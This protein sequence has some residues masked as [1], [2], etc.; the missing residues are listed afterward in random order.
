RILAVAISATPAWLSAPPSVPGEG[1][2]RG[3]PFSGIRAET[4]AEHQYMSMECIWIEKACAGPWGN[5]SM[6]VPKLFFY[7]KVV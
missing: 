2:A 4:A 1:K 6:A 7:M 5:P 3:F